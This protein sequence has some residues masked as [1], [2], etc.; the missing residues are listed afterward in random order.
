MNKNKP[1]LNKNISVN[2]FNNWYWYKKEL[3]E[4]CKQ[5]KL[6]T[7]GRK[8]E[9]TE[10]ISYFLQNGCPPKTNNLKSPTNKKTIQALPRSIDE[11]I[12][13]NY[14]SSELY[15]AYFKSII[16]DHFHFT[17]YMMKYIKNNPGI[18]FR[19]Y[20][21]EW[22]AEHERRKDKNYKPDIMKSCEYNQYI[23]D[24]FIDN[25]DRSLKDAIEC[26]KHIKSLPG[27]NKYSDNDLKTLRRMQMKLT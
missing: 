15:R 20:T 26:W 25:K 1:K 27:N 8:P 23:R 4:F 21:N 10:R 18:T 2:D 22:Q 7:T 24:F 14:T 9:L 3:V 6:K 13:E 12:P 11:P 5:N 19:Q 16:G 17:A